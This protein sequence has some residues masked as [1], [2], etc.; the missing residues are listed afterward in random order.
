M[1]NFEDYRE[2]AEKCFEWAREAKTDGDRALFLDM[3]RSFL[4]AAAQRDGQPPVRSPPVVNQ[5]H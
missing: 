4:E 3:A 5:P 2:L 1:R